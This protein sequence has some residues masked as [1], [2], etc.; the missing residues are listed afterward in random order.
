MRR[1]IQPENYP[2]GQSAPTTE[3]T[4]E[5]IPRSATQVFL[6][7]G[8]D[9]ALVGEIAKASKRTIYARYAGK[10]ALFRAV[11]E[12]RMAHWQESVRTH[13]ACKGDLRASLEDLARHLAQCWLHPVSVDLQRI[14][15]TESH[16][17]P[18]L[19][20]FFIDSAS[21]P[22]IALIERIDERHSNDLGL[23]DLQTAAEQ[24]FGL[25][26]EHHLFNA[27]FGSLT[28]GPEMT[29]RIKTS[30]DIFLHGVHAWGN[31]T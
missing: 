18:D 12:H 13:E 25:T 19:S 2:A 1:Q 27:H 31:R 30:V 7:A 24:F 16:R 20:L 9:R 8:Y 17:W 29:Q 23:I 15:I 22:A 11:I 21:R 5:R 6:R 4:A 3:N 26:I 14:V 10:T 28:S